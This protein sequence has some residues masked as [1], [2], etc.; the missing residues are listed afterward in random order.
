MFRDDI[1]HELLN[2]SERPEMRFYGTWMMIFLIISDPV[3]PRCEF[4]RVGVILMAAVNYFDSAFNQDSFCGLV[5][6]NFMFS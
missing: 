4:A 2:Y 6:F 3:S 1:F 5:K